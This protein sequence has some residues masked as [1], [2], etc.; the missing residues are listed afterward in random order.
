MKR[1]V[2]ALLV[3]AL[4][5]AAYPME[6]RLRAESPLAPA[7]RRIGVGRLLGGV[8]TGAFRPLLLN[9]L[10]LRADILYGQGRVD[11]LHVLYRTMVTLYPNNERAR[12]FLGWLLAYNLR[13]EAPTPALAW[14]WA[15]EGVGILL[16]VPRGHRI[17]AEWFLKQCGQNALDLLRYAGPEWERE[18]AFRARA[19]AWGERRFGRSLGRFE[20]GLA[21]LEGRTALFDEA[22]RARLLEAQVLDDW[23]RAGKSPHLSEAVAVHRRLAG[24]AGFAD[25][26]PLALEYARRARRLEELSRGEVTEELRAAGD[27]RFAAAWWALGAHRRDAALLHAALAALDPVFAEEREAVQAWIAYVEGGA[28]GPRPPLPFD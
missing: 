18:K 10:W 19:R 24:P 23:M 15:E 4:L 28:Q 22:T 1:A 6:A 20:L 13:Q 3:V 11:E 26:P 5:A 12:E 9:Y 16:G 14:R 25:F 27:Y 8:L 2:A 7:A 21:V 17:V